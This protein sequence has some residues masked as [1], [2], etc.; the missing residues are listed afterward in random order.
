[1]S[2]ANAPVTLD[3]VVEALQGDMH[4]QQQVSYCHK[5]TVQC[6]WLPSENRL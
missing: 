5:I 2:K 1:M 3:T 4:E 6:L